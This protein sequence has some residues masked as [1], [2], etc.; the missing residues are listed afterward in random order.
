MS[1]QFD[2]NVDFSGYVGVYNN[3]GGNILSIKVPAATTDTE[4]ALDPV[5]GLLRHSL[6]G[7]WVH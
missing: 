1:F 3:S 4:I 2:S 5:S 6:H 7:M